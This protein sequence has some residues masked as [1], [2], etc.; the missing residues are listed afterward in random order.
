MNQHEHD[1]AR[2]MLL[3]QSIAIV[4]AAVLGGAPGCTLTAAVPGVDT[5]LP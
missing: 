2:R 4:S 1:P 5:G 3:R